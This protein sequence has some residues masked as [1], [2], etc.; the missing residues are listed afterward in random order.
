MSPR[1]E[2]ARRRSTKTTKTGVPIQIFSSGITLLTSWTKSSED[3][4]N[5]DY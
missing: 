5:P 1:E 2:T 4:P 3:E